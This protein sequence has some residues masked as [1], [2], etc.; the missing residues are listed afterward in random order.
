MAKYKMQKTGQTG[1]W[2]H[3]ELQPCSVKD[4]LEGPIVSE[5]GGYEFSTALLNDDDD[6]RLPLFNV[7]VGNK[8]VSF[9]GYGLDNLFPYKLQEMV[10]AN[11]ITARC[12][13]F[14]IQ[15]CYGQGLKFEERPCEQEAAPTPDLDPDGYDLHYGTRPQSYAEAELREFQLRNNIPRLFM[16][17]VTDMKFYDF[18]VLLIVLSRDRS[19]IVSVRHRDACH[20]RLTPRNAEGRVESIV[21]GNFRHGAPMHAE[22]FTLLDT[23]DPLG[24]LLVR[25]GREADPLTGQLRT[26]QQIAREPYAYAILCRMPTVGYAYYPLPYYTAIFNDYWYD[27]YRLIGLGKRHLIQNT[28]APRLQI[29]IHRSYWDNVCDEEHI[30]DEKKRLERK[31]KERQNITDFCTKPE[32]AGK[33]WVTTFD[34]T[35]DGQAVSMVRI[36]NLST[37]SAKEGGDWSEDMQEAANNIC[38]AM[39]VHPNV[40]GA[41]PGKSQMNNSGSDKRELFTLKQSLEKTAHDIILQPWHAI[42]HYNGWADRY[43][44]TVPMVELTTLDK[45][46]SFEI[47]KKD[48]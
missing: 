33:A 22:Q 26:P 40:V 46:G 37:G 11:S 41:V 3:Y 1:Q 42:L 30:T 4:S 9:V 31:I 16:E 47:V 7:R 15:T 27:I 17:Q 13:L 19:K 43:T 39:G 44:V 23:A 32:N 34:T 20:V 21:V 38:F 14:N 48:N 10:H 28:S 24:D 18:S 35:I 5:I 45:G 25:Q 8:N 36:N 2:E 29:E 6:A 12:Q